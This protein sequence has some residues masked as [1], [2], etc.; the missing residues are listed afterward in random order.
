MLCAAKVAW[1]IDG[2]ENQVTWLTQRAT[3][4]VVGRELPPASFSSTWSGSIMVL[5]IGRQPRQLNRWGANLAYPMHHDT[6]FIYI[7]LGLT[8]VGI[9]AFKPDL[10]IREKT[11]K[12]IALLCGVEFLVGAVL[13]FTPESHSASGALLAPLPTFGYFRLCLKQF[14]R[15]VHREPVDVAYNW[16]PG[17]FKDR[18]F[19]FSFLI[20]A[21]LI[22]GV[23]VFGLEKL[24]K[25]GW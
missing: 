3:Q 23:A 1:L 15:I 18:V 10:L 7:F 14:L 22:L 13:H 5:P 16:S 6:N 17:L 2:E 20:G 9:F 24:A 21:F 19:A 4:Q 25:L 12:P 8:V 11:F